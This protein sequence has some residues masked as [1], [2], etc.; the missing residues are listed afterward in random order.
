MGKTTLAKR[1]SGRKSTLTERNCCPLIRTVSKNH[2]TTAALGDWAAELNVHLEDPVSIKTVQ[3]ELHKSTIH[4]R[5]ATAKP[6]ITESNAHMCK[7][8]CHG[9]KTWTSDNWKCA[10]DMVI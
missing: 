7:R 9:H 10:C 3:R 5:V 1:N 4:G 8:W 2:R 6:L